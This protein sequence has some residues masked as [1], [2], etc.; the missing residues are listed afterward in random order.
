MPPANEESLVLADVVR[1]QHARRGDATALVFDGR[2]TSFAELDRRSSRA[3]NALIAEG[4]GSG[5]RV[6]FLAKDSDHVYELIFGCAKANAV[7][8]GI[9]WRLAAP[10]IEFILDDAEAQ[11][12]F[13]DRALLAKLEPNLAERP[14]LRAVVSF[15]RGAPDGTS[16]VEWRDRHPDDD[17]SFASDPEQIA[18]HMYTSGTTGRPKGVMLA[19]RSFFAVIDSMRRAGDPWIGFGA[20]DVSLFNIPSFHIGGL[21]WAVTTLN[22]GARAVIM[23]AFSGWRALELIRDHRVTKVCMV[24]AMMQLVLLEPNAR[25]VDFSSLTHVVYGGSPISEPLLRQAMATFGCQFAQIYG[26]TETGN[27]AVC[28][29]PDDHRVP[30]GHERVK[31]AGRPYPGVRIKVIDGEGNERPPREVG[32]ICIHSPANMLGY[33]NRDDATRETLRDGW[34]HTGDAG[35]LDEEGFVYV[36]DRVKDMIIYAG[37]NIYP[38]EIEHVLCSH[39]AVREAAVIG[40]PD[41]RWGEEVKAILVLEPG[42]TV[43]PAEILG[44][45]RRR[46]ADFKVPRSIDFVESLPRTPSGKVKKAELRA[47][48]WRGRERGVN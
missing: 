7:V 44:H 16:Y 37:E 8:L 43:R 33:W 31:A 36:C 6:A 40:V 25:A 1:R 20:D 21:W 34:V 23:D 28:L 13:A 30:D 24:P 35:F 2:A 17:P 41:E 18:V 10:E 12:L 15:D 5:A 3:A 27:T 29:R 9:N 26:L 42:R 14:H 32:E 22:A 48:Y 46:L 47:P 19:N 45:V 11:I 39:P 38:A 4:I